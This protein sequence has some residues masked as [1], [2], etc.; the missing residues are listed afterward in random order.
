MHSQSL[1]TASRVTQERT[2]RS[3]LPDIVISGTAGGAWG[4]L[5]AAL[6]QRLSA[7]GATARTQQVPELERLAA[8]DPGRC[9]V[10]LVA[11]P[12][13]VLASQAPD[14]QDPVAAL[15]AW[16]RSARQLL[17][18]ARQRPGRWRLLDLREASLAPEA[19]AGELTSW[20][21]SLPVGALAG[22]PGLDT[23]PLAL[24]LAARLAEQQPGIQ[25]LQ[26]ELLASCVP[27]LD[28]TAAAEPDW[29]A[30]AAGHR[31][32]VL[33]A[34][35][36]ATAL[37]ALRSTLATA[38][39]E[40]AQLLEQLH[41]AQ[42]GLAR[43]HDEREAA[44]QRAQQLAE[45]LS[46]TTQQADALRKQH[47]ALLADLQQAKGRQA[48]FA[49]DLQARQA[50][51]DQQAAERD[52][53]QATLA[54]QQARLAAAARDN[55]EL[56]E[57]V[58]LLQEQLEARYLELEAR[59]AEAAMLHHHG[60]V[61]ASA[62]Q[63]VVVASRNEPPHCHADIALDDLRIGERQWPTLRVRLVEHDTHPGLLFWSE[64][65]RQPL[66]AW[67][68][69]G[70]EDGRAFLLL[71]PDSPD[72]RQRLLS[73]GS[74]DWQCVVGVAGV[75]QRCLADAGDG[76]ARWAGVAAR[77]CRKLAHLPARL[78]YDEA[79]VAG[80]GDS[81]DVVFRGASHGS[82]ALGALRLRWWPQ[83][84]R[85][86][87]RA[88]DD[89]QQVPLATWPVD[90]GGRLQPGL[91]LPVGPAFGSA[92]RRRLWAALPAADR[93]LV[94]AVLDALPGA[95]RQTDAAAWPAGTS[96]QGLSAQGA[97]LHKQAR[98]TLTSLRLRDLV[99][100]LLG[101]AQAH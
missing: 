100:R 25:R 3:A 43:L 4:N 28:D 89:P 76:A 27:L 74:R 86:D 72:S 36:D 71:V 81:V 55:M 49:Q 48:S 62:R 64:E 87:W 8:E 98:R 33:Q 45:D 7:A 5:A 38:H 60:G 82:I 46:T 12:D 77:L 78:R 79:S 59:D 52:A 9:F 2:G 1:N 58:H 67:A 97:A 34:R 75:L 92:Q 84:Q 10:A 30:L 83:Q 39:G 14:A 57:H 50:V 21:L 96:P 85:I 69:N 19:L 95:A 13:L 99:R 63:A 101:R 26:Q 91:T 70:D 65:G 20:G 40:Q 51:I 35:Q 44:L 22:L 80:E 66:S 53:A 17:R 88:P 56:L 18:L 47:A 90:A 73:L 54:A 42:E 41:L 23:E 6:S 16:A 31:A 11:G 94:L 37:A 61:A 32:L 24:L 15:D 29:Q 93:A 68:T